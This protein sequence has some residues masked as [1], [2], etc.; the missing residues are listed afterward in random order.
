MAATVGWNHPW[1]G[2]NQWDGFNDPGVETFSGNP[3]KNL[4]REVIQNSL[5]SADG[6]TVKVE[7]RRIEIATS[8]IPDITAFRHTID[9]CQAGSADESEKAKH[10]FDRAASLLRRKTLP[11]L[12]ISDFHTKGIRGPAINGKPFFAFMKATGQSRKDS[13]TATGSF[14]IGKFAP[15]AVSQLRTVF[16]STVYR[17]ESGHPCQL[18]QG[19]AILMS[20]DDSRGRRRGVGYWGVRDQ[21]APVS[22]S[23][24]RIAPWIIRCDSQTDLASARG[25]TLSVLAFDDAGDWE[26]QLVVSVC[27]NF[28]AAISARKL[29]VRVSG[30]REL[31]AATIAHVLAEAKEHEADRETGDASSA[32][33]TCIEYLH[34][35]ERG[36]DVRD[37]T[38]ELQGLGECRL[39]VR[40]N[41]SL[42]KKVCML[43]NGMFVSDSLALPGLKSF[44]DFKDFVAVVECTNDAGNEL[45]RSMEPPRHDNF[46]PDRL[47]T[48]QQRTEGR[49]ALNELAKWIRGCI[50]EVAKSPVA[51][52]T[53]IDELKEFFADEGS[54]GTG[55]ATEEMDPN[56]AIV[57][58]AKQLKLQPSELTRIE[59]EDEGPGGGGGGA[60]GEGGG[61]GA[62]GSGPLTGG[63]GTELPAVAKRKVHLSNVRSTV[64]APNSRRV[65]FSVASAGSFLVSISEMGADTNHDLVIATSSVGDVQDGKVLVR[66]LAADR[67]ALEVTMTNAFL[68]A[69]KVVAHEV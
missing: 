31:T 18:T 62:G 33:E 66:S 6:E 9:L 32:L 38:K 60:T 11:V 37:W 43:R 7:F 34:A 65:A 51:E 42:P 39:L 21:C 19:K 17:D 30:T 67:I 56:G 27:E 4:A 64:I 22:G 16:V 14:G 49:N 1:D 69:M 20:H 10:F 5:D 28:F 35:F 8:T 55:N 12:V 45:L 48:P 46:E 25:T 23:D 59:N 2:A 40:V 29:E 68:G 36:N 54:Q 50:K 41:D 57:L 52:V 61:T 63:A 53:T 15:Y 47:S 13:E 26:E 44:P 3:I 24:S 58:R